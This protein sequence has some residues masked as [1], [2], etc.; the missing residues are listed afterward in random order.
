M[1]RIFNDTLDPGIAYYYSKYNCHYV[2]NST[3]PSSGWQA[4]R[5]LDPGTILV[6]S[7]VNWQ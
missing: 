7:Q 3:V 6:I 1:G 2:H 4:G 5:H